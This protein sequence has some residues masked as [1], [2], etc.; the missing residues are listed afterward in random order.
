MRL[1]TLALVACLAAA[2]A[3]H[4][5]DLMGVKW[6]D[7][8]FPIVWTLDADGVDNISTS[9]DRDEVIRAAQMWTNVACS[10]VAFGTPSSLP[11]A[12]RTAT[13]DGVNKV[14]WREAGEGW[15][16]G[17]YTL[18]VTTP[19]YYS[20]GPDANEI[21][22]ADIEF[23]GQDYNWSTSATCT[24]C[25]DVFSIALHEL[26][27][28]FGLDHPCGP[29]Q[30][31]DD[32][33]SNAER[34]SIMF[35]AYAG[36]PT[37]RLGSD[38][39]A[40]ACALYPQPAAGSGVQGSPC[41]AT[42]D[43]GSGLTCA[44]AAQGDGSICTKTCTTEGAE[45][46]QCPSTYSCQRA[47]SGLACFPKA[48]SSGSLCKSCGTDND[49]GSGGVC[50]G[51]QDFSF[52]SRSCT[53]TTG[54]GSSQDYGC[55]DPSSQAACGASTQGC[56]CVPLAGE[57]VNN[58]DASR[59]CPTGDLCDQGT[60][61]HDPS[62]GAGEGEACGS[63]QCAGGLV[64]VGSSA[65]DAKCRRTCTPG[66]ASCGTGFACAQLQDGSGACV[67][68][69][70]SATEGQSC[71][72]AQCGSGLVCIG[73]SQADA[74]CRR[75]CTPGSST[76]PTNFTCTTL[77]N[78]TGACT[79]ST[80]TPTGKN[81][82]ETCGAG[83]ACKSGLLCLRDGD[84]VNRCRKGC[85]DAGVCSTS[86]R[87][88]ARSGVPSFSGVCGCGIDLTPE[89]GACGA[90]NECVAGSI[91]I[92]DGTAEGAVCRRSC[93]PDAPECEQ[94]QECRAIGNANVC[95]PPGEDTPDAG[96]GE[97]PGENPG[98]GNEEESEPR[99]PGDC[100]NC[101]STGAG[102]LAA[103]VPVVMRRRRRT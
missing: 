41:T 14:F 54:C 23:N 81:E 7:A 47:T 57:C 43:C 83:S 56:L 100:G 71:S 68:S 30:S 63:A 90:T 33:S 74:K 1:S 78:G 39:T 53:G 58:C 93:N 97:Q 82:C 31:G 64:C 5:Y 103:F 85:G 24:D 70:G 12:Q 67:P 9:A 95:A 65:A 98:T 40:A 66:T 75:T 51:T 22:D 3:A 49:C 84:G 72:T 46:P 89:G 62:S 52:C 11:A 16:Y 60:C 38:D 102:L 73:T 76:C 96:T 101:S 42:V 44:R 15:T 17:R 25:T 92:L 37:Q 8:K 77:S 2:P 19:K 45:S 59:P 48:D 35:A 27:H 34:Q 94:D 87:C 91:C 13:D 36:Y 6:V 88:I 69:A 26:G 18:G 32:C 55:Y 4:A 79:P 20:S 28:F 99:S 86:N 10:K 21:F 61:K 29:T 80:T 50:V